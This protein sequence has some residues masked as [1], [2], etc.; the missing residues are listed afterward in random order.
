MSKEETATEQ[1]QRAWGGSLPCGC[2]VDE[3]FAIVQ[4]LGS[5]GMSEVYRATHLGLGR[6]VALKLLHRH[7]L[8]DSNA[9]QRF[10]REAHTIAALDHPNI[11]KVFGNG[12]YQDRLYMSME[13]LDGISLAQVLHREGKLPAQR[14]VPIFEQI[15]DALSYAHR[16]GVIHRD[17]KPSNVMLTSDDKVKLVDFGLSKALPAFD[18]Q[19][20]TVTATGTICGTVSYM[21]PEQCQ[22]LALNPTSDLYSLGGL[23][24]EVLEGAPPFDGPNPYAII[25]KHLEQKPPPCKAAPGPLANVILAALEK[26]PQHRPQSADVLKA[27]LQEPDRFRSKAKRNLA[28]ALQ[29]AGSTKWKVLSACVA[30]AILAFAISIA[31]LQIWHPAEPENSLSADVNFDHDHAWDLA[32]GSELGFGMAKQTIAA[33]G[34][35]LDMARRKGD[36]AKELACCA[37]LAEYWNHVQQQAQSTQEFSEAA[38]EVEAYGKE[39]VRL[40]KLLRLWDRTAYNEYYGNAW[41]AMG[42]SFAGRGMAERK[43]FCFRKWLSYVQHC[44]YSNDEAIAGS[45]L[46]VA[47]IADKKGDYD[48]AITLYKEGFSHQSA[49]GLPDAMARRNAAQLFINREP[50]QPSDRRRE[51]RAQI[52]KMLESLANYPKVETFEAERTARERNAARVTLERLN[53]MHYFDNVTK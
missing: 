46:R 16:R 11:V 10:Q 17:I 6:D 3:R 24:Y 2:L 47:D 37:K 38:H 23:M 52:K 33:Y 30:A 29:L 32:R 35:V 41:C 5:G 8:T 39:A 48:A 7:L 45:A 31:S 12:C 27:H 28:I 50:F 13:L 20:Q 19:L 26:D 44:K 43:E 14:A 51:F 15:C 34:L 22:G 40:G 49:K 4:H 42:E 21:S 18:V 1:T 25:A 53:K 36:Q 9:Q